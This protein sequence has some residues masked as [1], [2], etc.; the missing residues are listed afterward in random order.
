MDAVVHREVGVEAESE[1]FG[2]ARGVRGREATGGDRGRG[3]GDRP[4]EWPPRTAPGS[5][6]IASACASFTRV[7]PIDNC[8]SMFRGC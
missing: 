1:S 3:S 8:D 7:L 5:P 4:G 6:G 2:G